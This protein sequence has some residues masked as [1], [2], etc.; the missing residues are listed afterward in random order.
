MS[1][2]SFIYFLSLRSLL[3]PPEGSVAIRKKI[4]S[5]S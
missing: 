5:A 4:A 2:A 3:L 1:L